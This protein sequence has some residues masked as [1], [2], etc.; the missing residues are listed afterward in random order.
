MCTVRYVNS[1][2]VYVGT[3]CTY[4]GSQ[5]TEGRPALLVF[6]VPDFSLEGYTATAGL[7]VVKQTLS[8]TNEKEGEEEREGGGGEGGWVG[9]KRKGRRSRE[10]GEG[11]SLVWLH[12]KY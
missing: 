4:V 9:R 5:A 2:M 7:H 6:T 11:R 8:G 12:H 10:E 1:V 3:V